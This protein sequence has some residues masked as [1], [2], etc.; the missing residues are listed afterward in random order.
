M[1]YYIAIA[2]TNYYSMEVETPLRIP[3]VLTA[4]VIGGRQIPGID[5]VYA[6][7][8]IQN[9]RWIKGE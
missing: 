3:D 5:S 8:C 2:F 4:H 7:V 1:L 9:G 6:A